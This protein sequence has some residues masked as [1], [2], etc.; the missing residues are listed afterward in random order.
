MRNCLRVWVL[1]LIDLLLSGG[2]VFDY[3]D[4]QYVSQVQACVSKNTSS[5]AAGVEHNSL[6][7]GPMDSTAGGVTGV[8]LRGVL[9][10][11]MVRR[12]DA[13]QGC[14]ETIMEKA[15][16][17]QYEGIEDRR[18][19]SSHEADAAGDNTYGGHRTVYLNPY[20]R[21]VLPEVYEAVYRAAQLAVH[22]AGWKIPAISN[23]SSSSTAIR[24]CFVV[25][26][27]VKAGRPFT[28]HTHEKAMFAQALSGDPV[29][30]AP[31]LR[32]ARGSWMA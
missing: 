20:F 9:S 12:V 4:E 23:F 11:A 5:T 10:E 22:S 8:A 19:G 7:L 6:R 1:V 13:L 32:P 27:C 3:H 24:P 26:V 18:F 28:A 14:V 29:R 21:R 17:E 25:A 16:G 31:H 2:Y 15:M 30:G